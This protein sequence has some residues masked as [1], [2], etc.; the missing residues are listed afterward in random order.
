MTDDYDVYFRMMECARSIPEGDDWGCAPERVDLPEELPVTSAVVRLTGGGVH[1][2]RGMSC[3]FLVQADETDRSFTCSLSGRILGATLEAATDSNWTGRSC[4]SADPDMHSGAAAISAWRNKRTAFSASAAAYQRASGMASKDVEFID[5]SSTILEVAPKAIKRGAPCVDD[6]DETVIT[7][8]KRKKA[9]KRMVS[10]EHRDVQMRL[11]ADASAVVVKLFST[12]SNTAPKSTKRTD[13]ATA[14]IAPA[15][16]TMDGDPR[17]EN[18]DFVLKMGLKR[19]VSRCKHQ[20]EQVTL[21][22]VHDVAIAANVFVKSRILES[23]AAR[24]SSC[25]PPARIEICG[26]IVEMCARLI[27]SLWS[28]LCATPFFVECQSGDSFRPFASGVMYGMKRGIRMRNGMC[29]VP[30]IDALV[31]QLP[32]LRSTTA[33]TAAKQL[34]ASSH[35]GLCSVHRAISSIEKMEQSKQDEML[36]KLKV[37]ST[38][39]DRLLVFVGERLV[40]G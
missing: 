7:D 1:V 5:P 28:V 30:S 20:N 33:T 21:S 3:K 27:F 25:A 36:G 13:S 40:K 8:R 2:C 10:L 14:T 22:G 29:L 6:V 38:I 17:L 15:T 37:V 26:Q 23:N 18:L 32:E 34:Q 16:S 9:M 4:G 12:V 35:R 39:G 31:A 19:Y 24:S 11:F